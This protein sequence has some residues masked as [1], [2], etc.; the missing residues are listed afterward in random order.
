VVIG[1]QEGPELSGAL[2]T[3]HV[4]TTLG[5]KTYKDETI[6]PSDLPHEVRVVPPG[7]DPSGTIDVRVDGY[8]QANWTPGNAAVPI[9]ERTAEAQFVPDKTML[10]RLVLQGACLLAPPGS[11]LPGAPTCTAPQTCLAGACQDDTVTAQALEP[12]SGSWAGSAPDVCK[13][14]NAGAPVVQVGTG[15]TDYLPLTAGQMVQAEQGPQGGH[16]IWIATRQENLKQAGST[17]TI[18]SVQPTTG[19]AGP[20]TSF[21]FT[22]DPDEGGFCKLA[23]LRYQLDQ[24]GADYHL[25]LGQPLDVTVVIKDPSGAI[26]TGVAHINIEP[27]ILC[28]SGT[29]G[30]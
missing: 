21:V 4:V 30:C 8:A 2:G 24:D 27:T 28:P 19:M 1:V 5:G 14:A 17:T 11:P 13:P 29:P 9:L 10:L 3:L 15:Q 22:F 26:G 25:F 23:G 6:A 18:T 20:T 7:S 16:H 12:Y